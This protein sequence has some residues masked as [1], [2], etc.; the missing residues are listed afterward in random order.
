MGFSSEEFGNVNLAK[1]NVSI[2]SKAKASTNYRRFI[3]PDTL[4]SLQIIQP[5]SHPNAFN[6]GPG[7]TGSKESLSI[8]GL[9]HHYART[10]QGKV[11]LRQ[12]FLRPSLDLDEI[13]AR[14]DFVGVFVRPD[15]L[16]PLQK[17]S[18]SISRVKNIRTVMTHLH[19]GVNGGNQKFGGFKSGAWATLLEFAYHTID[20]Q[21]T[22]REVLG[23][24]GLS[25]VAKAMDLLDTRSL[26]NVGTCIHDTVDLDSS[27]EQNRTVVKH[28][29]NDQLDEIKSVYDGM[30]DLLS[31]TALDIAR[32]L[33]DHIAVK[34]NV[35]YFPQ[36]GY[37]ITVPLDP[38]TGKPMY[39]GDPNDAAGGGLWERMFTTENQA[40]LKDARMREMDETLGDLWNM[41]CGAQIFHPHPQPFISLTPA[42]RPRDRNLLRPSPARPTARR[43]ARSSLRRLRR[44]GLHVRPRSRRKPTQTRPTSHDR[45][46]HNRHQRLPPSP[47]RNDRSVLRG[48]RRLSRRRPR[49]RSTVQ[50]PERVLFANPRISPEPTPF[51]FTHT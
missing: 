15:N 2:L 32:T 4:L 35:I 33:P 3:N 20:I 8:Y 13:N 25:L 24:E 39:E 47:P 50:P 28:G 31:R 44:T 21:S 6:Q 19:K 51:D 48:Q 27:I 45:R 1:H 16:I 37:H 43:Y 18:K 11:R 17:L 29:I 14:L 38:A 5:E 10:P 7:S 46:K 42:P 30:D 26:Q 41:I 40:Y 22:L 34:L 23:A 49:P 36:L 12:T 9:F